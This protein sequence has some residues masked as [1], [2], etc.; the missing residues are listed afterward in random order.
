MV[1]LDALLGMLLLLEFDSL[2]D[3][4]QEKYDFSSF[5]ESMVAYQD[6]NQPNQG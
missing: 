5:F 4:S 1:R 2:E 6:V 3:L